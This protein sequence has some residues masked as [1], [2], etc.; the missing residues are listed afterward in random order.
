LQEPDGT[1][2]SYI[3]FEKT[4]LTPLAV[5]DRA[6][7]QINISNGLLSQTI[8]PLSQE[9]QKL[10]Q[11]VFSLK[12]TD[13]SNTK[14]IEHFTDT[15]TPQALSPIK[16]ASGDTAAP[17]VLF[18]AA[19]PVNSSPFP[20][21]GGPI[22]SFPHIGQPPSVAVS[23][24]ASL[25]AH[26]GS[27]QSTGLDSV[28]GTI[29]FAD[30]NV[31]DRP[32]ASTNFASLKLLDA[33]HN[34]I[35]AT[36]SSQQIAAIAAELVV[37]PN[38][39]NSNN[40][41]AT[42][43]YNVADSALNFLTA[44]ETLTLT[45]DA[46]VNNNFAASDQI[47]TVPFTITINSLSGVEWIHPTGGLWSVGSNWS[48]GTV[49]TADEDAV[50][51]AQNIPGGSGHYDVT[52][53]SPAFARNLTLNANG[54]TGG[55]VINESMLTVGELVTIFTDGVLDNSLSGTVHV[56][57]KLELLDQASLENFGL[58]TLG[59]GGDFENS[60]TVKN[61]GTIEVVGGTLNVE[62]NVTNTGGVIDIDN[63]AT[64]TLSGSTISGG[65]INDGTVVGDS[66]AE[67]GNIDVTGSSTIVNASLNDGGLTISSGVTLT[68]DDDVVNAT[69][70]DDTASGATIQVDAGSV[71]TLTDVTIHGGAIDQLVSLDADD[72]IVGSIDIVGLTAI[73][74][75][76]L[77]GGAVNLASGAIL[78]L[79]ND[80]VNGV[81]VTGA[82]GSEIQIDDGTILTLTGNAIISG[83]SVN[84]GTASGIGEQGIFGRIDVAGPSSISNAFL[85]NGEVA[86]GDGVTLVLS[87]DTVTGTTFT[88]TLS[89]GA[90]GGLIEV[91]GAVTFQSGVLVNGGTMSIARGAT[92]DIENSVTGT[93][94]TLTDVDVFN[95]GAIQI[96]EPGPGT[97]IISLVL[98]GGTTLTGGTLL[99]N[100][101]FPI[102]G[103]EG[104]LEIGAG[105]ATLNNLTVI[106]KNVLTVDDGATLNLN[107]TTIT[108]GILSGDGTIATSSGVSVFEDVTINF[109]T[110]DVNDNSA[111]DLKGV[112]TNNGVIAVESSVNSTQL[113]IS[114]N[115]LLNGSGQIA[116][117]DNAENFIVSDGYSATLTNAN[118]ISGAGT[119]GDEF[120]ALVNDGT[121]EAT[122]FNPLIIDTG[123]NAGVPDGNYWPVGSL[124]VT[125]DGTGVLKASAGH[126]L[127]I[128]DDVLNNG[129]IEAG[130][131]GGSAIGVV[132]V[133]G[134]ITGTGSIDIFANGKVEIGG[135]VSSGQ[136]V[137]F[138]SSGGGELILDDPQDFHGLIK[139]LAPA[140][141]EGAENFIDLKGFS[142]NSETKVSSVS[143]DSTTGITTVTMT[144]GNSADNLTINVLGDY[145]NGD[146]RFASDGT[147]GT[148]ISDPTV[149]SD[150]TIKSGT[151]LE[152]GAASAAT[153]SFANDHG[154]TGELVLDASRSFTG[155][156]SGFSGNGSISNSDLIDLADISIASVALS[157]TT[158]TPQVND[159]G[160]L[161]L[162]D[163]N[164]HALD[165]IT[166]DG[167][168]QLAN[169]VIQD[170]GNGH[171]L[172]VDPP[173]SFG[174]AA[175]NSAVS[176]VS[177]APSSNLAIGEN[178]AFNFAGHSGHATL[179]DFHPFSEVSQFSHP[180][181]GGLQAALNATHEEYGNTGIAAHEHD[182]NIWSDAHKALLHVGDFHLV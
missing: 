149:S 91:A 74:G 99:I 35:T 27:A 3:L 178:F 79:D 69:T 105:D 85:T 153:V 7:Q 116:L 75:A 102:H 115:V 108:G 83:G 24:N 130:D 73:D 141:P 132:N 156:I 157:K 34:D 123:V 14:S 6:G 158:Y 124:E 21:P 50:I 128:D 66:F 71:L 5:V 59:Q 89:G 114:G 127:Q 26:S 172:I 10:I 120:L 167:S 90:S 98:D 53:E 110:I 2:G 67:S 171:T 19:P 134:S 64:L 55:E 11:D 154:N 169:F 135:S 1:T 104:M 142:Y 22:I 28:S 103:I 138:E 87:N 38:P 129:V 57:Q 179:T 144:D 62:V 77:N 140:A 17:L 150:A 125:N 95:S 113:E 137:I 168:Y 86:V 177:P 152:V 60:S 44:G 121:I 63:G 80:T 119:I 18:S 48:S 56:G 8:T 29:R 182:S 39:G 52:I 45:Y 16:L 49:P 109:A 15:I 118:T 92:L 143:F 54:T 58:I 78:T 65:L 61:C 12:F 100:A 146:I 101:G 37:V 31:G 25:T 46:L 163:N 51:P 97:T 145:Y 9:I 164:G 160:T 147:G 148:L 76:S 20:S 151:T 106:N 139:V 72:P 42:W 32:T 175:V 47:A 155:Q 133:A 30:I 33:Q 174:T 159:A 170:D 136:T 111:L 122:G 96:D 112:I 81:T 82:N 173:A 162:Y 41:S 107:E 117:T 43:T 180:A 70:I 13:S 126:V 166:F 84:V 4:T 68:L 131:L 88:D 94:A 93:G 36:L 23:G 176:A 165:S 181:L 161:T 40:G